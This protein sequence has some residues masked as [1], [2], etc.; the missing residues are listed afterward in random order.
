MRILEA[1]ALDRRDLGVSLGTVCRG[2]LGSV[3]SQP[4]LD[5]FGSLGA[6]HTSERSPASGQWGERNGRLR[7]GGA[8]QMIFL[9]KK[10]CCCLRGV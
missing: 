3:C 2:K 4:L 8:K 7:M 9:V 6:K 10:S 5:S 1:A